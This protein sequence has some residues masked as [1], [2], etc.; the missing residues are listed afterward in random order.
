MTDCLLEPTDSLMLYADTGGGK[1]AQIGELA[2]HVAI[3]TG[4]K[5]LLNTADRGGTRTIK[6]H[7]DAGLIV[8]QSLLGQDPFVAIHNACA[9]KMWDDTKKLWVPADLSQFGLLAFEGMA[10]MAGAIMMALTK[11]N[12]EGR[13]VGGKPA[14]ILSRGTGQDA[15]KVSN[16]TVVDYSVV[17][18]F[19]TQEAWISQ[20]HGLP[21]VW[22]SH[23]QRGQDE[24]NNSPVV[25]PV[26]AG[27]ALTTVVPRWFT[28]T[29]RLE[30]VPV[31]NARPRHLLYVEEH[32]DTGLKG[33]GNARLPLAAAPGFKSMIEPAS[34]VEALRSIRLAQK[35]AGDTI[36]ARL[37]AAGVN[38]K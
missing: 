24:E 27:K 19:I 25:G 1:T 22:T 34:V 8:E 29:F 16:N 21:C 33:F 5:T 3:A 36:G 10:S 28:Y 4:K 14:F 26:V 12:G 20:G 11:E 31:P 13:S 18:A 2:E 37:R 35:T 23:I 15:F 9:G 32:T 30:A 6:P 7:I 38:F 17:Q